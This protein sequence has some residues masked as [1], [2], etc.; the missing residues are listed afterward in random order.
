[1]QPGR[2]HSTF[3]WIVRVSQW[4][5]LA[6]IAVAM[7]APVIPLSGMRPLDSALKFMV[8]QNKVINLMLVGLFGAC[9]TARKYLGEPWLW[10]CIKGILAGFQKEA[11]SEVGEGEL[12]DHHRITLYRHQLFCL[13]PRRRGGNWYWPWGKGNH[14][15]SGWLVP[16]VRA[17][18]ESAGTTVFLASDGQRFDG[19][20][21]AAYFQ[22]SATLEISALP[23]ITKESS[24][25]DI[26]EYARR[27]FAS[28]ELVRRRLRRGQPCARYFLAHHVNVQYKKWGILM[29]DTRAAVIPKP[30]VNQHR[31]KQIK[32]VLGHLLRRA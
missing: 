15:W 19:V 10:D 31:F 9:A 6:A 5:V 11:F 12:A 3:Y 26:T 4:L 20:C 21:G 8:D 1:M 28:E 24:D 18:P 29:I 30:T 27:A 13:W 14:P 16:M 32:D 2:V 17:G 22:Q 7:L 25:A 23:N